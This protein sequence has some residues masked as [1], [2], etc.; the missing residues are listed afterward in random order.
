MEDRLLIG[1]LDSDG[2]GEVVPVDFGFGFFKGPG[3]VVEIC[4]DGLA[5]TVAGEEAVAFHEEIFEGPD[6]GFG[7]FSGGPKTA[8][9]R[10]E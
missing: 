9:A 7:E 3:D 2:G 10:F 1:E 8:I 6:T 5:E 4:A